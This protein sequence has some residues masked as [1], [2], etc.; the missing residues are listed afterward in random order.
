MYS[1]TAVMPFYNEEDFL[2]E[3][4]ERLHSSGVADKILLVDDSSTDRSKEIAKNIADKYI[5]VSY[6]LNKSNKGKGSAL[7]SIKEHIQTS[8]MVIHDADLEYD[9]NDL[10]KLK[11]LSIKNKN[12]L[13]LGSRF[14]G[15]I[16]RNNLYKSTHAA[17]QFLS[18]LFSIINSYKITDIATCYKMFPAKFF[19]N[20][21]FKEKGFSIEIEILA[22]FLK[23]NTSVF[24]LPIHYSGRSYSQGKKIHIKDGFYY[25]FNI[26]KYRF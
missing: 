16:E 22:K 12:S 3:S 5:N 13:I 6:F 20:T 21:N 9:P 17:N 23:Y 24:E 14:I 2:Q 19:K 4:F 7:I 11:K 18:L 15:S 1:L 10:I 26:F 8:H 25:I